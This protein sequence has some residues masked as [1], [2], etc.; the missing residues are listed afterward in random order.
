LSLNALL[1]VP[2]WCLGTVAILSNA[3]A[4]DLTRE[5]HPELLVVQPGG[6]AS[7]SSGVTRCS[8]SYSASESGS[9]DPRLLR[10]RLASVAF[11][12]RFF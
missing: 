7:L 3:A 12:A 1:V 11:V 10:T 9:Q 5:H 2:R 6:E 8:A 4:L